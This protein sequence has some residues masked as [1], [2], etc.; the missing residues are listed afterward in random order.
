MTGSSSP[1]NILKALNDL[2]TLAPNLVTNVSD[3]I[4]GNDRT[5]TITYSVA[6]GKVLFS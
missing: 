2:P 5:I 3:S 6:L 4:V 1:A